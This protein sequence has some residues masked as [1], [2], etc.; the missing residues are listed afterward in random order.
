MSSTV[1]LCMWLE[2]GEPKHHEDCH[3][4]LLYGAILFLSSV[5]FG[6]FVLAMPFTSDSLWSSWFSRA[7]SNTRFTLLLATWCKNKVCEIFGYFDGIIHGRILFTS[8]LSSLKKL[9]ILTSDF[10]ELWLRGG[11]DVAEVAKYWQPLRAF[12]FQHLIMDF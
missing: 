7:Y 8:W 4:I 5:K 11:E 2:E 6:W 10:S 1:H 9:G 3:C 12:G